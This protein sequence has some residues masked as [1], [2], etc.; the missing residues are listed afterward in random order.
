MP[1][2]RHRSE[3]TAKEWKG[4]LYCGLL[5]VKCLDFFLQLKLCALSNCAF[6]LSDVLT[7]PAGH[8]II[9]ELQ[10]H[11]KIFSVALAFFPFSSL[12]QIKCLV[13]K[14]A[15]WSIS[16]GVSW[17]IFYSKDWLLD[18]AV[19]F[20]ITGPVVTGHFHSLKH[21]LGS[22]E[23]LLFSLCNTLKFCKSCGWVGGLDQVC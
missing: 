18:S 17:L 22:E 1:G 6:T 7:S 8:L 11:H 21:P 15:N 14:Q 20:C 3:H 19:V 16:T 10:K 2:Y 13:T 23:K 4:I 5:T 12:K 9:L